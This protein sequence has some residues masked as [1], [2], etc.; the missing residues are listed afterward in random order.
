M[1]SWTLVGELLE[2]GLPPSHLLS[3]PRDNVGNACGIDCL[4]S[5][6]SA[7]FH[8]FIYLALRLEWGAI[9]NN[10]LSSIIYDCSAHPKIICIEI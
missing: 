2:Y 8:L 9:V 1:K 7:S 10:F 3:F 5:I 6:F 4:L